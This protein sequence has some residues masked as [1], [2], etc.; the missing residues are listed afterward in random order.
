MVEATKRA[1]AAE[2]A[3]TM[4]EVQAAADAADAATYPN[5]LRNE[6]GWQRWLSRLNDKELLVIYMLVRDEGRKRENFFVKW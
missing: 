3:E 2:A 5:P 4:A 6:K 1:E